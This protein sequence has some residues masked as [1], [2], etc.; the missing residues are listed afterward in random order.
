VVVDLLHH[1]SVHSIVVEFS[2]SEVVENV[3]KALGVPVN[4]VGPIALCLPLATAQHAREVGILHTVSSKSDEQQAD[5]KDGRAKEGKRI[6]KK[7][8]AGK[9]PDVTLSQKIINNEKNV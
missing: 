9:G 6:Y 4:E 5:K 1:Q 7:K 8:E 3:V 2:S